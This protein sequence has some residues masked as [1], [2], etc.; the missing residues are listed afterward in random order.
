MVGSSDDIQCDRDQILAGT[1]TSCGRTPR[2]TSPR[3]RTSEAG[4]TRK[5]TISV[6]STQMEQCF[7]DLAAS[8]DIARAIGCGASSSGGHVRGSRAPRAQPCCVSL[9]GVQ[10]RPLKDS[11]WPSVRWL[12]CWVLAASESGGQDLLADS[13][14]PRQVAVATNQTAAIWS[15]NRFERL[16]M[17]S[18]FLAPTITVSS[19]RKPPTP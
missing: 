12:G 14:P 4:A 5:P 18:G 9:A 17:T 6:C 13:G 8:Q 11:L 15:S 16:V 1:S 7:G 10:F 2:N 3:M 19:W